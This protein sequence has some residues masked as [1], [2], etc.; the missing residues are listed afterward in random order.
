[1]C[2]SNPSNT[3][4]TN[5]FYELFLR[6]K[7]LEWFLFS[8]LKNDYAWEKLGLFTETIRRLMGVEKLHAV[9]NMTWQREQPFQC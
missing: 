3:F 7:Y 1:M 8:W 9:C 2:S 4:K 5:F 6:L